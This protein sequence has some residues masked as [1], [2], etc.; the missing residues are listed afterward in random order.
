[1][2][3]KIKVWEKNR[4]EW[5]NPH[6]CAM[7]FEDGKIDVQDKE[8]FEMVVSTNLKDKNGKEI[9]EGYIVTNKYENFECIFW[10]GCFV[11]KRI[12]SKKK[13]EGYLA[14]EVLEV[15]GNIYENPELLEE[16]D[17]EHRI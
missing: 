5:V 16:I 9:Y 13:E 14:L 4:K 7:I 3:L 15:I 10:K 1:M 17:N 2:E 8:R 11:G 12:K 6:C